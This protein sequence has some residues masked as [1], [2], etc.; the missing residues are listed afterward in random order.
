MPPSPSMPA[1]LQW[2]SALS[3]LYVTPSSVSGQTHRSTKEQP[4]PP[5]TAALRRFISWTR[6]LTPGSTCIARA[7]SS[8][9][10]WCCRWGTLPTILQLAESW[11]LPLS[12]RHFVKEVEKGIKA[13]EE[14]GAI[15]KLQHAGLREPLNLLLSTI[16]VS[17]CHSF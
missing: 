15:E 2:T 12:V 8:R 16:E 9:C 7:P 4:T 17:F 6:S 13:L 1:C 14:S 10:T 5:T 3:E 11:L